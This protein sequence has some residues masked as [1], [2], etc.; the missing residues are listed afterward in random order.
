MRSRLALAASVAILALGLSFV[1][2]AFHGRTI[3]SEQRITV[4]S[5]S[6]SAE[7][8]PLHHAIQ[9]PLKVKAKSMNMP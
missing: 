1:S 8:D 4:D 7:N 2:G 5:P 6:A 9:P 3:P